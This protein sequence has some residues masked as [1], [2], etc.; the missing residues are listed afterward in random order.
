MRI[1]FR[2]L[3]I[4]FVIVVLVLGSAAVAFY[5]TM[6]EVLT[7]QQSQNL[8][9]SANSF[10]YAYQA[11]LIESEDAFL[12]VVADDLDKI[13]NKR[14]LSAKNIDFIIEQNVNDTNKIL[15][16]ACNEQVYLPGN[17]FNLTEFLELNPYTLKLKHNA[18]NGKNI[19]LEELYLRNY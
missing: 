2:I 8:L 13:L 19:S 1:S 7:S 15:R 10:I 17:N 12:S 18:E 16:Y 3:L 6:Y 4:N 9:N 5:S 14:K 11:K